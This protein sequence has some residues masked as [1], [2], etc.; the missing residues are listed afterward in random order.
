M[1]TPPLYSIGDSLTDLAVYWKTDDG[2]WRDFSSGWSFEVKVGTEDGG[3]EFTKSSG[4]FGAVG[5]ATTPS[6]T[7][8]WATSGEL[9]DI[10]DPG[11][12]YCQIR[13]VRDADSK[14]LTRR[15]NIQ[16]STSS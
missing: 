11:I 1:A 9:S 16:I 12:Y 6:L 4:I 15:G 10:T 5:S 7:I 8:S 2:D 14:I 13:C 3:V